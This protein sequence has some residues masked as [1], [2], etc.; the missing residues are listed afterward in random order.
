MNLRQDGK[1]GV[2]TFPAQ[3]RRPRDRTGGKVSKS[4]EDKF[5]VCDSTFRKPKSLCEIIIMHTIC[6]LNRKGP[7]TVQVMI[8][9]WLRS[10]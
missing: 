7:V 10:T 2:L 4:E 9:A 8:L 3:N 6:N 5:Q 1:L